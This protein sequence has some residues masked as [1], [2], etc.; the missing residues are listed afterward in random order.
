MDMGTIVPA[1]ID[2]RFPDGT[3][4]GVRV[5]LARGIVEIRKRGTNYYFDVAVLSA[6]TVDVSAQTCY[7]FN[8]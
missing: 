6:G 1:Y 2:L 8:S 5:D 4:S 3:H 7:N